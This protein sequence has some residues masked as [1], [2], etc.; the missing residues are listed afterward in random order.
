[1]SGRVMFRSWYAGRRSKHPVPACEDFS[2]RCMCL[3]MCDVGARKRLSLFSI[4]V[5][6]PSSDRDEVEI[7]VGL[8]AVRLASLKWF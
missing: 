8:G 4:V 3:A 2:R 7:V 5:I 6:V 1:M